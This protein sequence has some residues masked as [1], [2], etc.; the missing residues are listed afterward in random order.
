MCPAPAARGDL[1]ALRKYIGAEGASV[2]ACDYD[3]RSALHLAAAEGH[4][5][6][7][8]FLLPSSLKP[9]SHKTDTCTN[10]RGTR[11]SEESFTAWR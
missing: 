5:S 8:R 11:I 3:Q 2:N 1:A 10:D 7:V 4:E 6:A 9:Q